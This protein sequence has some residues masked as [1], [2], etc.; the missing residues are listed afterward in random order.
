MSPAIA[1][2]PV[3]LA[4]FIGS[5]KLKT[6]RIAF[7]SDLKYCHFLIFTF[8]NFDNIDGVNFGPHA[9]LRNFCLDA[10]ANF[11]ID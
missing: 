11:A 5:T 9:E 10:N 4:Q 8:Q 3:P 2:C 1:L 6:T 7:V